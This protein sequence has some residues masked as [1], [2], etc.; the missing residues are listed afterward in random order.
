M[1]SYLPAHL[2][3]IFLSGVLEIAFGLLLFIP[4]WSK[5]GALG[6]ILLLIA[7]FPVHVYMVLNPI[8]FANIASVFLWLRLP[9]QLLL[10]LWAYWHTQSK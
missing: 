5:F 10:I 4:K 3:L 8:Q 1:P 9:L 2:F 6:I 7:F